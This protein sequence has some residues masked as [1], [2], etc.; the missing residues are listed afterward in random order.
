MRKGCRAPRLA[1]VVETLA[2]IIGDRLV[3]I[4]TLGQALGAQEYILTPSPCCARSR[5]EWGIRQNQLPPRFLKMYLLISIS[6]VTRVSVSPPRQVRRLGRG[7][8]SPY[9]RAR[10]P[11]F[12]LPWGGRWRYARQKWPCS[13][14]FCRDQKRAWQ[15]LR[16][17]VHRSNNATRVRAI[18]LQPPSSPSRASYRHAS[19]LKPGLYQR[20]GHARTCSSRAK[21]F[22]PS[23][24]RNTPAQLQ[25]E[26]TSAAPLDQPPL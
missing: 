15:Y 17:L 18:P 11:A 23:S 24:S 12:S 6:L 22:I 13:F 19:L 10:S 21:T 7:T 4:A 14:Q 5:G 26:Q 3:I 20:S 25:Q 8:S 16:E 9:T 1:S 2:E